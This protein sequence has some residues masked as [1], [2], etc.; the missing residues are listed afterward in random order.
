MLQKHIRLLH[1]G[2]V[3]ALLIPDLKGEKKKRKAINLTQLK[4]Q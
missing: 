3:D 1:A 4:I 2:I